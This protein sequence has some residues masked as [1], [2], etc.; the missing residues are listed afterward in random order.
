MPKPTKTLDEIAAERGYVFTA[1]NTG[2]GRTCKDYVFTKGDVQFT[3][4]RRG[5]YATATARVGT[6]R[7]GGLATT[8]AAPHEVCY[9]TREAFAEWLLGITREMLL[10]LA[11]QRLTA[12]HRKHT[13]ALDGVRGHLET[14]QAL[15]SLRTQDSAP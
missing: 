13:E 11:E 4:D 12:E 14:V 7:L 6:L 10:D 2:T 9:G 1:V 5:G 3:F 8:L 15:R